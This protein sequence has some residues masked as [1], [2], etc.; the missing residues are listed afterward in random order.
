MRSM[1]LCL[2][3][4][5]AAIGC[6]GG[7]SRDGGTGGSAGGSASDG[8]KGGGGG[9]GSATEAGG[10]GGGGAAGDG[11]T[12]P[13]PPCFADLANLQNDCPTSDTC[14]QGGTPTA[15]A[16]CYSTGVKYCSDASGAAM[17]KPVV[18]TIT[19]KDGTTLCLTLE[20]TVDAKTH[21][22]TGTWKDSS[23]HEIMT[24]MSIPTD[25]S[26]WAIEITCKSD[27][28]SYTLPASCQDRRDPPTCE[29]GNCTCA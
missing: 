3:S 7:S 25:G 6:G 29:M 20:T 1:A 9:G 22:A 11:G 10:M 15:A 13:V 19:K 5:M 18:T 27:G 12:C 17:G 23:G 8:G 24:Y 28:K 26:D 14:T 4:T 2:L 16:T 21:Q